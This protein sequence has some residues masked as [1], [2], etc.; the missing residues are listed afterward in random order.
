VTL[1][2]KLGL[3]FF[4]AVEVSFL[5]AVAGFWAVHS[6]QLLADDLTLVHE[7]NLRLERVLEPAP[8]R[9]P[10]R[11]EALRDH[12][13]TLE[14]GELIAVLARALR[15]AAAR[16]AAG[17]GTALEPAVRDLKAYYRAEVRRLR[18]RARLVTRLSQG[19]LLAI[20][21]AVLTA[22]MAHV[23]GVHV[24]LVRPIEQLGRA[25]AVIS[26]GDLGHRIP[27]AGDDEL[28]RLA[29]SINAMAGSLADIQARLVVAERFALIGQMSAYVAHN[30]RNPLASIRATAQGELVDLPPND[31]RRD[32]FADIVRAADRLH[33][34]VEDFLRFSSPVTLEVR[35]ESVNAVVER[36][37]DLARP[38]IAAKDLRLALALAPAL[39]RVPL[40]ASKMEQVVSAVLGNAI[41]AS[42]P[43]GTIRVT[44]TL[45][46]VPAGDRQVGVRIEDAG[47]GIPADRRIAVFTPFS[48]SKR[49]GTGLGLPLAHKIVT[50]HGGTITLG[51]AE[52]TGAVVEVRLPAPGEEG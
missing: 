34:W 52:G 46:E 25:T 43:G 40:D 49:S 14:E 28:G 32:R 22:T 10:G 31:A 51:G 13:Q 11:V 33:A 36:A 1:R 19:L 7:Q 9:E 6:W 24:W 37:L 2:G 20:I 45:H 48:T 4:G 12:A 30:I 23:V 27:V 3:V 21:A 50:A 5:T 18:E 16:V 39:P 29:A 15:P 42:P 47:R 35:P 41:E 26:T 8:G 17:A 38:R 44:T